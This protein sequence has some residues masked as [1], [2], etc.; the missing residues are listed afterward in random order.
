MKIRS[1][2]LTKRLAA[3]TE[4]SWCGANMG[5]GAFL[6]AAHSMLETLITVASRGR[7]R[8]KLVMD[9]VLVGPCYFQY[10]APIA[11]LFFALTG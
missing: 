8:A 6:P 10:K 7:Y 1:E 2:R 9:T 5:G 11:T 4:R 3:P